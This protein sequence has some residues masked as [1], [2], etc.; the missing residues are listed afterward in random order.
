MPRK[1]RWTSD[2]ADVD[3]DYRIRHVVDSEADV[4]PAE[5]A[6]DDRSNYTIFTDDSTYVPMAAALDEKKV[7]DYAFKL[8]AD[9]I[10]LSDIPIDYQE[11][12]K[13]KSLR[14]LRGE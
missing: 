7:E 4:E 11:A 8:I 10:G 3:A 5:V 12:V 9:E 2:S 14:I 1:K 6:E 13:D